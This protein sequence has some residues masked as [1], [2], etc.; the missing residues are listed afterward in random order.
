MK[1]Y[2]LN[3][4]P[5]RE[6]VSDYDNQV[7]I[8][9]YPKVVAKIMASNGFDGFT[10]YKVDGYWMGKAEVSFKIE[11]ATEV[12]NAHKVNELAK[13]LRDMYNQD[14]VMVTYPDNHVEFI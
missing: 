13:D 9:N 7:R 3:A 4:T 1:L 14:S 12:K 6:D 11:L 2:T 8:D 10:I 5:V